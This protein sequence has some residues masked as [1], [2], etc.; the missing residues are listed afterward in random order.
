VEQIAER[1]ERRRA[2]RVPIT[3]GTRKRFLHDCR[4]ISQAQGYDTAKISLDDVKEYRNKVAEEVENL[5]CRWIAPKC[6]AIHDDTH[7][8]LALLDRAV[9][10]M[11][12]SF[13]DTWLH[14]KDF[15]FFH[16]KLESRWP[17]LRTEM[18]TAL[19]ITFLYFFFTPI[20]FCNIMD[21]AG[22]C[23]SDGDNYLGWVSSLYFASTTISTVGYG[24]LSVRQDPRWRSFI[25]SMYMIVSVVIAAVAFSASAGVAVSPFENFISRVCEYLFGKE[26]DGEFLYKKVRRVK[27]KKL[28]EITIQ[29]FS[30]NLL[31]V[32]AARIAIAFEDGTDPEVNVSWVCLP[33]AYSSFL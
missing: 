17:W 16:S 28:G 20:L 14:Y 12:T 10:S 30:L 3:F 4:K 6:F 18:R 31:G 22:V 13:E 9:E 7:C 29:F 1:I 25:G 32:F 11:S 23:E 15:S 8:L 27:F 21:D 19:L 26:V 33:L 2:E 5:G 24:D